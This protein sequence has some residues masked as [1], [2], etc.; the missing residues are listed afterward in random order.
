MTTAIK[1]SFFSSLLW[2][3]RAVV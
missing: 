1:R 2:H 3:R